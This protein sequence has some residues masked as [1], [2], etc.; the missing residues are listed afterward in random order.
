MGRAGV[1]GLII[2]PSETRRI[3]LHGI[4]GSTPVIYILALGKGFELVIEDN[5][6]MNNNYILRSITPR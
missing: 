1:K 3:C 5:I 6:N 2:S 4:W